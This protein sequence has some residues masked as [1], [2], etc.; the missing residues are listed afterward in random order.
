MATDTQ[1]IIQREA[2]EI[3]AYKIGL[4]EQAKDLAGKAPSA[5]Q[6]ELLK[7]RQL[8]LSDLQKTG[9]SQLQSQID[10]GAGIGGYEQYLTDAD[11]TLDDAI[12]ASGLSTGAYDTSMTQDYMNPYQQAVTQSAIDQMN[13][14]YGVQKTG[15]DAQAFQ[16]GA[17]GGSRSGVLE[18]L[19]QGELADVSS[20]RIFEDLA[21]NYSQAQAASMGAF[22]NQQ[23]RQ[24]AQGS[25]LSDAA[26]KQAGLGELAQ[27]QGMADI[28]TMFKAGQVSQ[29]QR[30]ADE[31]ARL[32]GERFAYLEPQ[33]RLSYYGDILRGAPSTQQQTLVGGGAAEVPL[34]QQL[35]GA[36]ITGLGIYQ[37]TKGLFGQVLL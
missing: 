29:V 25:F 23:R 14:Q 24:A 21:R 11:A 15:R 6:I 32:E 1:N 20:K 28:D 4:M 12:A 7:K 8:G 19:A 37:G 27:K 35:A 22:E 10:A 34:W 9:L 36:G 26:L 30:E 2:P 33:Q 17:F 18:A 31:L 3:E 5:E 13:K 16:S